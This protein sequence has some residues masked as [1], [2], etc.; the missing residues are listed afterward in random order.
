LEVVFVDLRSCYLFQD[1]IDD[2]VNQIISTAKDLPMKKGQRIFNEGE[3]AAG[4][5]VLKSGAVELIMRFKDDLEMPMAILRNPGD[6]FGT[7][8]LVP[9]YSYSLSAQCVDKGVLLVLKRSQLR[10][11]M[12]ED[13]QMGCTIMTNLAEHYLDRLR[14]TRQELKIH[15]KT[16]FRFI[17]S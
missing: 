11:L 8:A 15:F 10:Q 16:L 7:G 9:P 5:H 13:L 2:R 3:E 6:C 1:L 4:L 12:D 14:Q 17:H